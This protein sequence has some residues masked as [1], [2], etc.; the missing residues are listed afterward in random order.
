MFKAIYRGK[1]GFAGMQNG[2]EY[3]FSCKVALLGGGF[4][5]L[6][7]DESVRLDYNDMTAFISDW[8]EIR[9]A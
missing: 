5:I 4:S 2:N 7:E 1:N 6:S 8:S 3:K 9:I